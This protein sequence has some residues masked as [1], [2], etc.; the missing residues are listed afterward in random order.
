MTISV[1]QVTTTLTDQHRYIR[2]M[3][4][5]VLV[6]E[7]TERQAAF[8]ELCR[9]LA[10]HEAA[11]EECLHPAARKELGSDPAVVDRRIDEEGEAGRAIADLERLGTSAPEFWDKFET[12]RQAVIAHAEAEEHE[13]LPT[14]GSTLDEVELARMQE[15]LDRVPEL[16]SR[17]GDSG[18]SF[19]ERLHA[20]R[21]EFRSWSPT[22]R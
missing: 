1:E 6:H 10:A 7:G 11:E 9:F 2:T 13:E 5:I 14:L 4:E 17:D 16:A 20:A 19:R 15:A 21:A 3:M 18:T 8:V 22:A 12:L